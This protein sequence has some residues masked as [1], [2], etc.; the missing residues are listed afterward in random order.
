MPSAGAI[1]WSSVL[2]GSATLA[3]FVASLESAV[4]RGDGPAIVSDFGY[5]L[6]RQRTPAT[7]GPGSS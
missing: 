2:P 3:D 6:S 5:W 4:A 7:E 1:G